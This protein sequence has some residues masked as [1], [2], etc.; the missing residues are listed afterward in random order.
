MADKNLQNYLAGV[1]GIFAFF[2]LILLG[3]S[4][5]GEAEWLK[6]VFPI[7]MFIVAIPIVTWLHR[8]TR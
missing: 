4:L 3:I 8:L 1:L 5:F 6:I 7:G 2:I